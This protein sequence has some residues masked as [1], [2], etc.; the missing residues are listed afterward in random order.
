MNNPT[1]MVALVMAAGKGTR[2]GSARPKVLH[3]ISGEPLLGFVLS[4]LGKLRKLGWIDRVIV[5][6][7]HGAEQ[8]RNYLHH[9]WP[10]AE[11][12][13][14]MPQLGTGHAVHAA[15][16]ALEGFGGTVFILSGDVPLLR[17]EL[18]QELAEVHRTADAQLTLLTVNN[19]TPDGYGRILRGLDGKLSGIVEQRDA[20]SS[21]RAI[22]EINA[23]I[24]LAQ[25]PVLQEALGMLGTANDQG[26]YYLTDAIAHLV[27]AG[28]R[29]ATLETNDIAATAGI[30]TRTELVA[31]SAEWR[32]RV[33]AYWLNR[34]VTIEDPAST[35]IGPRV[36]IGPDTILEPAVQLHG[37]TCIGAGCRIGSYTR[38][39]DAL[40]GNEVLIRASDIV[41]SQ[42]G[43]GTTVGPFARLRD[44][45]VVGEKARIGNFVELKKVQF[46]DGAKAAHLTYLGDAQIGELANI[47][48]GVVTCNYDGERKHR[49]I[50]G[51]GAFIGTNNTLV[52]PLE[53]GQE[54]YTAAGSTITENVP[55]KALALGRARQI[56]KEGWVMRRKNRLTTSRPSEV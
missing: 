55:A 54:A 4:T 33:C 22:S 14:Q 43:D 12:V 1:G 13:E 45:V 35:F 17:V 6:V 24:Y 32:Q 20:N 41:E 44:H 50:I 9:N 40:I 28:Q 56:I 38:L 7:G 26:E 29:V 34:Q 19:P 16:K 37:C 5:I 10:W 52:A 36:E 42:I 53:I 27:R 30:N 8:V 51:P 15:A 11:Y 31:A 47:G 2:M 49:T 39:V 18:L 3:E 23:G 46:G 25:W 21:Q 48:C